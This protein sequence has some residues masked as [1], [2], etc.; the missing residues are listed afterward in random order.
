MF[1]EYYEVIQTK[2]FVSLKNI[3][4]PEIIN[5]GECWSGPDVRYQIQQDRAC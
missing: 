5:L 2:I 1:R 3:Y 4:L